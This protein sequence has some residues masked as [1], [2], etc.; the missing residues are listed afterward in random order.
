MYICRYTFDIFLNKVFLMRNVG[1]NINIILLLLAGIIILAHAIIPHHHHFD[2]IFSHQS[3]KIDTN[4]IPD[5]TNEDATSY[6]HAFND[7]ILDKVNSPLIVTDNTS[8]FNLF[9]I[10]TT[11]SS[12]E[13]IRTNKVFYFSFDIVPLKQYSVLNSSLR[14]PPIF[15]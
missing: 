14:A 12:P 11:T 2:S 3:N 5:E 8:N 10:T 15:A 4:K 9:F 7:I 1:K 6:C 13:V